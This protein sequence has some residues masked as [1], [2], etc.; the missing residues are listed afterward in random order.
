VASLEASHELGS[1]QPVV[2]ILLGAEETLKIG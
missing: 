1:T 2:I